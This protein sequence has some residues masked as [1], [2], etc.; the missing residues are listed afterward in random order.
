MV[1]VGV[2]VNFPRPVFALAS[3]NFTAVGALAPAGTPTGY[4][5]ALSSGFVQ[6]PP[7]PLHASVGDAL[8]LEAVFD[9]D[10][11]PVLN[12]V[13]VILRFQPAPEPLASLT[14]SPIE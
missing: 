14:V 7:T 8:R 9:S 1:T 10:C 4:V 2:M 3:K 6:W 11:E 5:M 13:D 12:A